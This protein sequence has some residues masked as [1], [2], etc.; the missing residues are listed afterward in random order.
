LGCYSSQ[1]GGSDEE[2]P[3]NVGR[4]PMERIIEVREDLLEELVE[5]S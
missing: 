4:I 3:G 2:Q 5:S 1:S